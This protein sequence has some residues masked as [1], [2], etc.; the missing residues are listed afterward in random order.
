MYNISN[1]EYIISF[2]REITGKVSYENLLDNSVIESLLYL[3]HHKLLERFG[4]RRF[5][6]TLKAR[7]ILLL[8]FMVERTVALD[9]QLEK[10][11]ATL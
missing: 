7:G 11:S 6:S 2:L 5:K 3:G 4:R 9:C 1:C 10:S 8:D